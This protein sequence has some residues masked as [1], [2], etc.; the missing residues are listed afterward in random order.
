MRAMP[1][2]ALLGMVAALALQVGLLQVGASTAHASIRAIGLVSQTPYDIAPDGTIVFVLDLVGV[3]DLSV[4]TDATVVVTAFRP[5]VTRDEVAAARL[6]ELPRSVDSVE[7]A[8]ALLPQPVPGH[9]A[10]SVLLETT[11]RTRDALQLSKTGLYPVL[12]ELRAGGEVLADVLTFVH[13]LPGPDEEPEVALP[14]AFAMT[15]RSEVAFD[16]L[17]EVI[18]TDEI[19]AELTQL[20]QVLEASTTT[21]AVRVP[22]ALLTAVAASSEAGAE[23]VARVAAAIARHDVLSSPRS[24]LDPSSAAAAGS[25]TLYTQWLRDGEDDLAG[26]VAKP[27]RRTLAFLDSALTQDGGALLRDLGARLMVTTPEVFDALPNTTGVFTDFSQLVQVE[28]APGVTVGLTVTD[29][30]LGPVLARPTSTPALTGIYAITDL[31]AY[32]QQIVDSGGDPSRHG[33]TLGTPD[34]SPPDPTT[35]AAISSLLTTPALAPTTL[36]L[37]GVRTDRLMIDGREIIVGLPTV[38]L[39]DLTVRT[40]L[41]GE[42]TFE[43][44]STAGMLADGGVRVGNWRARIDVL[45]TDALSDEQVARMVGEIRAEMTAIRTA[46]EL[47]AGFSFS[48][49]GRSTTVP[50]KLYNNS[51]IA[52][53][54]RVRMTSSKLKF[55]DGDVVQELPPQSFTE[56]RIRIETLTNGRF[57]ASMQ[58]FTPDGNTPLAPPVPLTASVTVLSGL[59]NLITGALLL[60]VLSWWVRHMRKNRRARLAALAATS[61]NKHPTTL[62]RDAANTASSTTTDT[63]DGSGLSPDAAT[64]TL[65]HS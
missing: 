57:P 58:V 40:S 17:R 39:H 62:G 65:P 11:T 38:P 50:I 30:L 13:R 7:L 59:G 10:A 35:Y 36:D 28:V 4:Q 15:T 44:A 42:L 41:V 34:L 54:V 37:L 20:T 14:V 1:A 9:V 51:D 19:I 3:A 32:R 64:S 56:V 6:R 5:V 60:V 21:V 18:V 16:D 63:D 52:L 43:A 47:P 22:P 48:L 49:T 26:I 53:T 8:A 25:S 2:W 23:L 31:L 33:V 46:I 24:P 29:R 12:I 55:P 61:I 45:P 27:S